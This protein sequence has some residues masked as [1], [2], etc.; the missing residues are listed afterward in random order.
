MSDILVQSTENILVTG[1][2]GLFSGNS[3]CV[4]LNACF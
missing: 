1:V 4:L 3:Y 2:G